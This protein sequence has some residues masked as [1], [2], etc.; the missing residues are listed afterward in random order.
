VSTRR[1]KRKITYQL[2]LYRKWQ[3]VILAVRGLSILFRSCID[4]LPI[5]RNRLQK[6]SGALANSN[7]MKVRSLT[8]FISIPKWRKTQ[9]M[10]KKT[11]LFHSNL[12][13]KSICTCQ[14]IAHST[15]NICMRRRT[16]RPVFP[17]LWTPSMW[18]RRRFGHPCPPLGLNMI[19]MRVVSNRC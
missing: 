14:R 7:K 19:R 17:T 12:H 8:W 11:M 6:K 9:W 13:N 2:R 16:H 15:S 10:M 1:R 3:R 5:T 4:C 18:S